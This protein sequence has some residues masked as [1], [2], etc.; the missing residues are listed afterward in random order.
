[1]DWAASSTSVVLCSLFDSNEDFS[2]PS[3]VSSTLKLEAVGSS[4]MCLS[5]YVTT[6]CHVPENNNHHCHCCGHPKAH[7]SHCS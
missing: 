2:T 5:I 1:M 4:E 3:S 6:L 7:N